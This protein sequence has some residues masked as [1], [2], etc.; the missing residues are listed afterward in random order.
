MA[1]IR[2]IK[3]TCHA[4]YG[5]DTLLRKVAPCCGQIFRDVNVRHPA[6]IDTIF[7]TI[8]KYRTF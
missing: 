1:E 2:I 6:K 5:I 4:T 3:V 8:D 7:F